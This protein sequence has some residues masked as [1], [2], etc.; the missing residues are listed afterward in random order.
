MYLK[1]TT[2]CYIEQTY[3][4]DKHPTLPSNIFSI[5]LLVVGRLDFDESPSDQ[6]D[7]FSNLWKS[8]VLCSLHCIYYNM[9][10]TLYTLFIKLFSSFQTIKLC[11]NFLFQFC[12]LCSAG[13]HMFGCHSEKASK[14]WLAVDLAGILMGVIGC[15]LPAVHYAYYCLSVS[16]SFDCIVCR[17]FFY[18]CIKINL[19]WLYL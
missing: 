12:M 2:S 13:F 8:P 7:P 5:L 6:K 4:V 14:R 9:H 18:L 11:I 1:P 19:Y 3:S 15:Y 17:M 16:C 10:I